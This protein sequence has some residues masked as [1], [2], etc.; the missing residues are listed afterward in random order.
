MFRNNCVMKDVEHRDEME[1]IDTVVDG[2][3]LPGTLYLVRSCYLTVFIMLP[4]VS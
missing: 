1:T 3:S 4:C 2:D